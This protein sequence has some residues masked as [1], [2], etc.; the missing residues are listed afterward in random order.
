MQ[1]D[2]NNQTLPGSQ[3]SALPEGMLMMNQESP[4]RAMSRAGLE[5][6]GAIRRDGS[7]QAV[8]CSM[9]SRAELYEYPGCHAVEEARD[10]ISSREDKR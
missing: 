8:L 2:Q 6:C 3:N 5:V 9:Q 10:T 1:V 4:F 7:Q